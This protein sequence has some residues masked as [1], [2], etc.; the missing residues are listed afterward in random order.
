LRLNTIANPAPALN[1]TLQALWQHALEREHCPPDASFMDLGGDSLSAMHLIARVK[2]GL[3]LSVSVEQLLSGMTMGHMADLLAQQ[4]GQ[5]AMV[6]LGPLPITRQPRD[7]L[8]P[9]SHS[10]RRM[11]LVQQFA[12]DTTAYHV[13]FALRLKGPLDVP[14][15]EQALAMVWAR[16][17]TFRTRFVMTPH[18]PQQEVQP[19]GELRM[20]ITQA[21]LRDPEHD[22][23]EG[24]T[25]SAAD[26]AR[27]YLNRASRQPF[28]LIEGPLWRLY[29]LQLGDDDHVLGWISHHILIDLLANL[30]VGREVAHC[31]NALRQG[32]SPEL[33]DVVLDC[34]DHGYWQTS[35]EMTARLSPQLAYWSR[36]LKDLAPQNLPTDRAMA[37]HWYRSGKRITVALPPALLGQLTQQA[38]QHGCTPFM[39]LLAC[40][41]LMLGRQG[42][43]DDVAIATPIA[44][45][46]HPDTTELVASL[47]NTLVMR[48]DLSGDPG[49][50]TLLERVKA[51]AMQAYANQDL[52]FDLLVE[53]LGHNKRHADLPLG[54]SVMLNVQ[55]APPG[56][57]HFDDLSCARFLYDRG[58][59]QFPLTFTIDTEHSHTLSLE[60][61]DALFD[62][63]TANALVQNYL[64]LLEQVL[65]EPEQAISAFA[66]QSEP[67][68]QSWLRA[69]EQTQPPPTDGALTIDQ[70]LA[71]QAA[72]HPKA[73]A[74]RHAQGSLTYG[75]LSEQAMRVKAALQERGIGHSH[76]VGIALERGPW[77][78]SAVWGVLASGA[79]YVPLDP[80]Y[81]L[82][83]LQHMAEDAQLSLML[84]SSQET[85]A[86]ASPGTPVLT[87]ADGVLLPP[88][89]RQPGTA[90]QGEHP[91]PDDPAYVIYTSGTT[92]QPKGVVVPHR[93]VLNFLRSMAHTPG[94]AHDDRM[95][96][97]TTLSF[98][99]ALLELLLP[100]CQ[101]AQVVLA[102]QDDV[103]DG[104]ALVDLIEQHRVTIMQATPST[105][106]M[107]LD[108][109]WQGQGR[110]R[111]KALVGGEALSQG[112]ASELLKRCRSVW[113]MYG[114]T[115]TTIW[116]TCWPVHDPARGILIGRPID[117]TRVHVLDAAGHP[118]PVGVPGEIGIAGAGVTQ[119]YWRQP[120][121]S[122]ERFVSEPGRPDQTLYRTGDLG[123]W[124]WDGQLEHLGRIDHQIKV[125]GHRIEP[126]DIESQIS[127]HPQVK[128]CVVIARQDRPGD[129]RLVAYFVPDGAAPGSAALREHSRS[130][131]PDYMV[132][133]H[134]IP[135][136]VLPL[137]S[138]GKLNRH[139]LPAP[140]EVGEPGATRSDHEA[141]RPHAGTPLQ[142]R[143]SAIWSEL[144]GVQDIHPQDNFFD[145]GGH[146]LLAVQAISLM[147]QQTGLRVGARH[148]IFESLAQLAHTYAQSSQGKPA[149]PG[150]G[151]SQ[152]PVTA[153]EARPAGLLHRLLRSRRQSG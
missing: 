128:H 11:W 24:Q 68:R 127:Q 60:Y 19:L 83:R 81:P 89:P 56:K 3:G 87:L 121:L 82:A 134:F 40:L 34:A 27:T 79:A 106:R 95:L 49:F 65:H 133:Q 23:P 8:L 42:R 57:L 5:E 101:G 114:P 6:A 100:L 96:A 143:L 117:H 135:L 12:P 99:I 72:L 111:F 118:C 16:H 47:I 137:L 113:N 110:R 85:G 20:A 10:Q 35:P 64:G 73:I 38:A 75:Q 125:R 136:S 91:G 90:P 93:A 43:Q 116:S 18:G 123:R 122:A 138:N 29:L 1:P 126:G 22:A 131:L 70:L 7:Q 71:R 66:W 37:P 61:A 102:S 44:N 77:L 88:G 129:V 104:Q 59:T 124:T 108:A 58:A 103:L 149:Y 53:R 74:V 69:H 52:P 62:L 105:W 2:A 14:A 39:I 50:L 148:Y 41:S 21:D 78:I 17:D 132:P 55:N 152:D 54:L 13:P 97:V 26:K 112:L 141:S 32:R 146:S 4:Q 153:Q 15:L 94:L 107:M 76:R 109:G 139:A 30:V 36:Q 31:Y 120:A 98:D 119:G 86:L 144:L 28:D 130:L 140:H 150:S 142:L 145:L 84:A 63:R 25:V 33:P 115:E 92:G 51:T 147:A 46:H 80:T 48:T 67:E 45:R 9:L 151:E